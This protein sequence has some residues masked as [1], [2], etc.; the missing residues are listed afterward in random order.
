MPTAGWRNSRSLLLWWT[1]LAFALNLVWEIAQ[2]PFY[3]LYEEGDLAA[4]AYAIAHCTVGDAMIAFACYL[5]AAGV[6]RDRAWPARRPRA[7]IAVAAASGVAYTVFSEWLNVSVRGAWTYS[8]LMPTVLGIGISPLLQ[9]LA[10]PF[11]TLR[12]VRLTLP[13]WEG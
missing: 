7:G 6:T 5:V 9:W 3:T 1:A 11:L 8:D 4:I 10:V 2:I 13:P 12:V